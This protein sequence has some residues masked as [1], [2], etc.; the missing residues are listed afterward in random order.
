MIRNLISKFT[1]SVN[2]RVVARRHEYHFPVKIS[3]EPNRNTGNL[4]KSLNELFI[5]GET[6]DLSQSGIAFVVS[7]IR[8]REHYLVGDGHTL[9]AELDL[10]NGN[11]KMQIVGQRYEQ[12]GQHISTTQYLIGAKILEMSDADQEAYNE[13]LKIKTHPTGSLKL[14][15]R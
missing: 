13:F 14:V 10:P 3:F 9:N 11:V 7:A 6:K 12:T 1:K 4:Q 15:E 5:R 2:E 8:V